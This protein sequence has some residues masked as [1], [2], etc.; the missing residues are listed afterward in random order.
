MVDGRLGR[1]GDHVGGARADRGG[2][3]EG[4]PAVVHAGEPGGHVYGGLF[5]AH[6]DVAEIRVLLQRLPD[7][8][9]VA[10]PENAQGPGEEGILAPVALD[11]L[12]FKKAND[13]LSGRQSKIAHEIPP[14]TL[15]PNY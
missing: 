9:H 13:G 10:V 6:Q 2:A 7:P 3:H 8:A 1:A 12:V 14:L 5:V 15:D 11:V 4:A